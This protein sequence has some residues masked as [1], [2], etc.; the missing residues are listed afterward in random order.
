MLSPQQNLPRATELAF[1]ALRAQTDDQARWLGA[2]QI[3]AGAWRVSVLNEALVVD[4]AAQRVSGG[5]QMGVQWH[6]LALHYLAVTARPDKLAPEVTFADLPTARSYA[7]VYRQRTTGRLCATI[8]RDFGR[9]QA[10]VAAIG[11]RAASGGD[12]AFDFDVFPRVPLR[13]LWHAPDEEFAA[14]AT[15]L[16]PP[17]IESFFLIEDVVVLCERL[18]SRLCRRG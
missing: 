4:L 12:A 8:G 11:G 10:A 18:V 5:P 7:E 3:G 9:L 13:L 6:I 17:N 1:D 2:E 14:S 16:L 15:L